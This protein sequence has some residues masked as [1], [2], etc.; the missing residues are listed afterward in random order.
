MKFLKFF[1][2]FIFLISLWSCTSTVYT[3]ALNRISTVKEKKEILGTY[4]IGISPNIFTI[5]G[6]VQYSPFD[7]TGLQTYFNYGESYKTI[8]FA[9]GRY[10]SQYEVRDD[11]ASKGRHYD[12]YLGYSYNTSRGTTDGVFTAA[13]FAYK[14]RYHIVSLQGGFHLNGPIASLDMLIKPSLIDMVD[15]DIFGD[16]SSTQMARLL[17]LNRDPFFVTDV[18][19]KLSVGSDM[20]KI[21]GAISLSLSNQ[22]FSAFKDPVSV[23]IGLNVNFSRI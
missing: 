14:Y 20:A 2:F 23:G 16:I 21:Y 19:A 7:K 9:V 1:S 3:P 15:A 6:D 12:L 10:N 11:G 8:G 5:N 4:G 22:D 17:V 13:E 18:T